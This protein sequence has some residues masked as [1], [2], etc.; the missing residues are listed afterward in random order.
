MAPRA[1][2]YRVL[3]TEKFMTKVV[4]FKNNLN[5]HFTEG[6]LPN[7]WKVVDIDSEEK[8]EA[9]CFFQLNIKKK[10]SKSSIEFDFIKNTKKPY[11]VIESTPFRKNSFPITIPEKFYYRIGWNHFLR[12]GNFNNKNSPSDRWN[13]IK[14]IQNIEIKD[15]RNSNSSILL[16]LQ[17]PGDSSLNSLYDHF[18]TYEEWIAHAISLIRKY[19]DRPIIIRPHLKGSKKINFDKFLSKD[20]TLSQTWDQRTIY[21]GGS[22]LEDDFKKSY[23]VVA[24]N[25]NVLVE[26][27]CE[28]IPTFPLSEES[29]VWDISNRI[30]NL[31]NPN[32][33][34]DRAQWL[35]DAAYMIWSIPEIQ[36][37][38]AWDHLKGVYFK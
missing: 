5:K 35:Y 25:S 17:K 36:T 27:T 14:K 8:T 24:Y 6:I 3:L 20:I 30:E 13:Y 11:L 1:N 29:I 31:E 32:L 12:S 28:G 22:G 4:G 19:S 37:G 9:D 10:K 16:C 38:K 33:T 26:S 21:E 2:L 15:W 7:D 23:A 34:I 18:N